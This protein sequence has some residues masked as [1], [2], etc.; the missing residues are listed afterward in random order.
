MIT[1]IRGIVYAFGSDY[2]ILDNNGIGYYINFS[3]PEVLTLSTE[4][5]I[6]TYQH[7][8]ED[9]TVLYGFINQEELALFNKL[10]TVKGL[11]PKTAQTMLGGASYNDIILAIEAG[12]IDFLKKMPSIGAKTAQQIILDLKGKLVENSNDE[13]DNG[14]LKEA[15]SGFKNLGYKMSEINNILPKLRQC[16]CSNVN[17]YIKE[18]LKLLLL[19]KGG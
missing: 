10:I 18:G 3:H 12:N 14:L 11:G 19:A 7:F 6:F 5:T 16:N 9:A 4:I 15:I 8:R 2:V 1:F 13:K 17:D